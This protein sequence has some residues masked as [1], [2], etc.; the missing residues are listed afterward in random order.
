[1]TTIVRPKNAYMLWLAENR[2][3]L[4]AENKDF[5]PKEIVKLAGER[6]GKLPAKDKK[7]YETL[8]AEDKARYEKE[9]EA[10]PELKPKNKKR[11]TEKKT[12]KSA[13]KKEKTGPKRPLTAFFLWLQANRPTLKAEN[14]DKKIGEISKIAGERWGKLPAKDKKKYEDLAAKDKERY[15]KE[16]AAA[17][18]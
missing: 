12:K 16:K 4:V 8:A 10:N 2:P 17:A 3:K 15:E 14:P 5:K 7:K 6:W 11:S 13:E 1:M 18:Q 9:V